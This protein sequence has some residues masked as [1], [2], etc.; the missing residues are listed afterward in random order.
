MKK[1][2]LWGPV[3]VYVAFI[4]W[5]SSAPRQI[6][7]IQRFPWLDKPC[8]F[9][10]YAPLGSLLV[11]AISRSWVGLGGKRVHAWATV[12]AILVGSLD[13]IYQKFIPLR[14][15]SPWDALTDVI[16]AAA[17]QYLYRK[18]AKTP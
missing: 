9:L 11:R 4:F 5:L 17:G 18:R 8:H 12:G 6:P 10:E 14:I 15:S 7:G 13:E 2:H 3:A 1:F 16:G